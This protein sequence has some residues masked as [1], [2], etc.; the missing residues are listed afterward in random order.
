VGRDYL[1]KVLAMTRGVVGGK[2]GAASI[3]QMP[4]STL[5]YKLRKHG[6]NPRDFSN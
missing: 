1:A 6:L 5:Q 3:L 4:K 2:D